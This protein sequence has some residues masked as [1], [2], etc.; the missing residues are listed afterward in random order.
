MVRP[1]QFG[2]TLVEAVVSIAV[3]GVLFAI[4]ALFL[5][6]PVQG[7]LD[8]TR[9]AELSDIADVAVRRLVRDLR[10][11]LPNSVRVDA[12]GRYLEFLQVTGGGRY[13]S[14]TDSTGAGNAL[15]FTSASGDS[16]FDVIGAMPTVTAGNQVVV[17]N[18]GSGFT[19]ADAW[20][21]S[22]NNRATVGSV[23]GSTITLSAAKV[24]PFE[25]PG[26]RFHVLEGPVTYECDLATGVIRRY[27]GYTIS[28]A[29]A[30]P[31]SGGSNALLASRVTDCG[32]AYNA[33][34][35]LQRY[36]TVSL[37]LAVTA[38]S[39]TATLFAQAHVPNIP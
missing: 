6:S 36:G 21:A 4:V 18:L 23:A 39:E 30:T 8:T 37:R 19:G 1:R 20:A 12:S 16:T 35:L 17:F 25:S 32:F 34:E 28:A 27:W 9:R 22:G 29:Q 2:F 14:Q 10:L 26:R 15:D 38:E 13:R 24:F 3:V 7:Y 11:A 33:N 5:R 31:P